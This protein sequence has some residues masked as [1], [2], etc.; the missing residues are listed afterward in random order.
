MKTKEDIYVEIGY[1]GKYTKD[2]K[3]KLR[4]LS[5]KYHP[6]LNNGDDTVMKLINEVKGEIEKGVVSYNFRP[7]S[8]NKKEF[9]SSTN[10]ND[11]FSK[12]PSDILEKRIHQLILEREKIS[13]KLKKIQHSIYLLLKSYN[14]KTLEVEIK[15]LEIEEQLELDEKLG[16]KTFLFLGLFLGLSLLFLLTFIL[17]VFYMNIYIFL[18]SLLTGLF[19]FVPL[20]L[21]SIYYKKKKENMVFISKNFSIKN[22]TLKDIYKLNERITIQEKKRSDLLFQK[23]KCL[24]DIQFYRHELDRKQEKVFEYQ[25]QK[26]GTYQK[27]R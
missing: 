5:K 6:D 10:I 27:N 13:Q 11:D 15:K 25:N 26:S 8:T 4:L 20:K 1:L 16:N 23:Q 9:S 2:I 19:S 12:T 18:I 17:S 24:N 21:A 7:K 14:K 3:K 22:Q